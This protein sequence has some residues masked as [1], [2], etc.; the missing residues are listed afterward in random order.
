MKAAVFDTYVTKPDSTVMHFDIVVP[1]PTAFDQVQAFGKQYLAQ[2]GL[3]DLALTAKE[4]QF[5]HIEEAHPA[6]EQ[7]MTSTGYAIIELNNCD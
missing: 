1:D 7:Q 5:C 3:N 6:L 4:C 2:K